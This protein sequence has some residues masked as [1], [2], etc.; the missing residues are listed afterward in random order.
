MFSLSNY[1][2]FKSFVIIIFLNLIPLCGNIIYI[3]YNVCRNVCIFVI[4][5]VYNSTC[6][7]NKF[8]RCFEILP[9]FSVFFNFVLFFNFILSILFFFHFPAFQYIVKL[10]VALH[11]FFVNF[12]QFFVLLGTD[13]SL[14]LRVSI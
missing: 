12:F 6:H 7:C 11:F 2:L 5:F 10:F 14:G 9:L 1:L 3:S 4:C 13:A 8:P